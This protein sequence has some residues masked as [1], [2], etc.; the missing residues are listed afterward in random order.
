MTSARRSPYTPSPLRT[1]HMRDTSGPQLHF[2]SESFVDEMAFHA[3]IDPV[4]FRLKYL[5]KD[6]DQ[7]AVRAAA[8]RASW[9]PRSVVDV[10]P[11]MVQHT[12]EALGDRVDASVQEL[13]ELGH[14]DRDVAR[15][16]LG[17]RSDRSGRSTSSR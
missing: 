1:S 8:E 14:L 4:A 13:T 12:R 10:A 7:A 16:Q 2:G 6:R 11:S 3:G 5:A 9:A 15:K 17:H